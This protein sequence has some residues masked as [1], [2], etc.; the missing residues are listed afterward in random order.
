[1]RS[2]STGR[3]QTRHPLNRC[4]SRSESSLLDPLSSE[5]GLT[6]AINKD[7][8][9]KITSTSLPSLQQVDPCSEY[10][11][12]LL[13]AG[14]TEDIDSRRAH[15]I[16]QQQQVARQLFNLESSSEFQPAT[17]PVWGDGEKCMVT[18][19]P[20]GSTIIVG[21]KQDIY[22]MTK[23]ILGEAGDEGYISLL[24]A[25]M[26]LLEKLNAKED[27][28]RN[29]EMQ[30]KQLDSKMDEM[31]EKHRKEMEKYREKLWEIHGNKS[32]NT[33]ES[34]KVICELKD[35]VEKLQLCSERLK[36]DKEALEDSFQYHSEQQAKLAIELIGKMRNLQEISVQAEC[37]TADDKHETGKRTKSVLKC[38]PENVIKLHDLS[39][40]LLEKAR[41]LELALVERTK[42]ICR[43]RWELLN[44]EVSAMKMKT[45]LHST[46]LQDGNRTINVPTANIKRTQYGQR[47][48]W[49]SSE[50]LNYKQ[51]GIKGYH[52]GLDVDSWIISEDWPKIQKETSEL[53]ET[54]QQLKMELLKLA[55]Q[56][57]SRTGSSSECLDDGERIK[58]EGMK[59][60]KELF[61]SSLPTDLMPNDYSD[62]KNNYSDETKFTSRHHQ[63]SGD[64]I[65]SFSGPEGSESSSL[66]D[67]ERTSYVLRLPRNRWR[68]S[69]DNVSS[70][71]ESSFKDEE[72]FTVAEWCRPR[73]NSHFSRRTK[74][75]SGNNKK[76]I[77]E[78]VGSLESQKSE[79][80]TREMVLSYGNH[81]ISRSSSE[82]TDQRND[83]W[84]ELYKHRLFFNHFSE[85]S[86]ST[87]N[88]GFEES[89]SASMNNP[90]QSYN[91]D[92]PD[93]TQ[94]NLRSSSSS[95]H[96][97][98]I[99]I[100]MI[101]EDYPG[102]SIG[103]GLSGGPKGSEFQVIPE[104]QVMSMAGEERRH[105]EPCRKFKY[106]IRAVNR[107][108]VSNSAISIAEGKEDQSP[109]PIVYT[110]RLSPSRMG[111]KCTADQ[112]VKNY[113]DMDE[114][115]ET[116]TTEYVLCEP[117]ENIF[118]TRINRNHSP[119]P[120]PKTSSNQ[121]TLDSFSQKSE[122]RLGNVENI[123]TNSL[124][125]TCKSDFLE[126]LSN[127][128]QDNRSPSST[129]LT[130][131]GSERS[132][133]KSRTSQDSQ[134]SLKE[135]D[136][137]EITRSSSKSS[138][139]SKVASFINRRSR[140][141]SRTRSES[142]K[143]S[144]IGALCRQSLALTVD[145]KNM[146]E[147]KILNYSNVIVTEALKAAASTATATISMAPSI[148]SL[149]LLPLSSNEYAA[150][151]YQQ[152]Q[153]DHK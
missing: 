62:T 28:C 136:S 144:A 99:G 25:N 86:S 146:N 14:V 44:R 122:S 1:M 126:P 134:V 118:F 2:S 48:S 97:R 69:H 135:K 17:I 113:E 143:Q 101:D 23:E 84:G 132:I 91:Y 68:R 149:S 152:F 58:I 141:K 87:H 26:F 65:S 93:S 124:T 6:S 3:H 20:D 139:T 78:Q 33:K 96:D 76:G 63:N 61:T 81:S 64:N 39:T 18:V 150:S 16:R 83:S 7:Q 15:L 57:Q 82:L 147:T 56:A 128:S 54:V 133:V 41:E 102:G 105:S 27:V 59:G 52:S 129:S 35:R 11:S 19:N 32:N 95:G 45:E 29:L 125:S 51:T 120:P 137:S 12:V 67:A 142:N 36:A 116:P 119:S 111:S 109:S 88:E 9:S 53:S 114:L 92:T 131:L 46:Q 148:S 151:T 73:T 80:L 22:E 104:G 140:S 145:P 10:E 21:S 37:D 98:Y 108:L 42:Q 31:N 123:S 40:S 74:V 66:N 107:N 50:R 127:V 30:L 103:G 47:R 89:S 5:N 43:L 117:K 34:N 38:C 100:P 112:D 4:I 55:S 106:S 24:E 85:T 138:L 70:S 49:S 115:L 60:I 79:E 75:S 130:S 153:S 90:F 121:E 110:I 72:S 13:P 77:E 94:S 71:S 8:N